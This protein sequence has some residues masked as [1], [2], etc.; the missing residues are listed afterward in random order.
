M[1]FSAK[2][3]FKIILKATKNQGSALSIEDTFFKK[4]QADLGLKERQAFN[5]TH[6]K[7]LCFTQFSTRTAVWLLLT[8]S[9]VYIIS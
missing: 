4:L 5:D 9:C 2:M 7:K 1:K 3:C 6:R 8:F